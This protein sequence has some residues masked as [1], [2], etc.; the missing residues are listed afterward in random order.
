MSQLLE[1]KVA[2]VTG[3]ARGIGRAI[4]ELFVENGA[5]VGIA[6]I[7]ASQ[8]QAVADAINAAGPGRASA[9]SL[10]V[11]D[12]ASVQRTVDA[13]VAAF[14]R[15][16]ILVNNAGIHRGHMVVDF[17]LDA[18]EQVFKVNV[19]GTFLCAQ[20]V[21]R[22]MIRQGGG[23]CIISMSSAS[24]KKPDPKGAAYCSS[25]SAIIGLTRVLALEL[26]EHGIRA[27]AILPGATDTEMLREV[28][29]RVPGFREEL[30][31]R[32]PLR[33]MADPRD[34]A[35]AALFLASD[36]ARHITGEGLVVSG[37]E[38]MDT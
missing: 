20:A 8:A 1:G 11:T 26:G 6:D 32:T 5:R 37:G 38:F 24:G 16:D 7:V 25:K 2:L 34:Q 13:L 21:A 30:M 36:L 19:T 9:L 12:P 31:A 17:P 28:V 3:A 18:W 27:N 22:Q 33:R 35:N 14:G 15:V 4:A 10:D 23:G 29:G